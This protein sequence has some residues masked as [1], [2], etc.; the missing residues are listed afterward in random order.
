MRIS[1]KRKEM[2]EEKWAEYQK[3]RQKRKIESWIKNNPEKYKE[4]IE[5][6]KNYS[7]YWRMRL[8][9]ELI[10]YKGG[11]C[12]ICG[13]NKD[14]PGV[15]DFHH[16]NPQKKEFSISSYSCLN[17]EKLKTEVDKCDLLCCR[18]HAEI[19]SKEN[20]E[21]RE[22][23]FSIHEKWM[24]KHISRKKCPFCY[25]EYMPQKSKQI[26]CCTD[27]FYKGKNG[28]KEDAFPERECKNCHKKY[29]SKT[30]RQKYCCPECA[31]LDK[32]KVKDRPTKEQI[33]EFSKNMP[34][35][36]IGEMFGVSDNA[37]RKWIK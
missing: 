20:E 14:F 3:E 1:K 22:T 32:R 21:K 18:C 23:A 12:I 15:Y 13:Y 6:R 2:G 28:K 10:F 19:H 29:E 17:R 9:K 8:K 11:R 34:M 37:V 24:N 36:K 4:G 27:C 30:Q 25:K 33:L 31:C 16:R 26:Y 7:A 5:K 35:T